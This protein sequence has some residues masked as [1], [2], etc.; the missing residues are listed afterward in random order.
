LVFIAYYCI[1]KREA[2]FKAIS[3]S[4]FEVADKKAYFLGTGS[5]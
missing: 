5:K 4:S 2:V 1:G 3:K